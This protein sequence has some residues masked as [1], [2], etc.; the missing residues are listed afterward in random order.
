[1]PLLSWSKLQLFI[2]YRR[3]TFS[4]IR[5]SLKKDQFLNP[6]SSSFS[7]FESGQSS[8]LDMH[9]E[10]RLLSVCP[11]PSKINE[12]LLIL[13]V[14]TTSLQPRVD[15]FSSQIA[16]QVVHKLL[17]NDNNNTRNRE[18]RLWFIRQ[19]LFATRRRQRVSQDYIIIIL[20][21]F[22]LQF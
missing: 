7:I 15:F 12:H 8:I 9:I 1:M 13:V 2:S 16:H 3:N 5:S 19:S 10:Q 22:R 20:P 17:A 4:P 21:L 11:C 14:R 6:C 18:P